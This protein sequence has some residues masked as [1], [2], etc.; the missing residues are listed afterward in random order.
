MGL[1]QVSGECFGFREDSEQLIH[2]VTP[3]LSSTGGQHRG[4]IGFHID[5]EVLGLID[6]ALIPDGT[7]LAGVRNES[8]SGTRIPDPASRRPH[9]SQCFHLD[10]PSSLGLSGTSEPLTSVLR[11]SGGEFLLACTPS[12]CKAVDMEHAEALREFNRTTERLFSLSEVVSFAQA[13]LSYGLSG[14]F[15]TLET[16]LTVNRTCKG[17]FS[18]SKKSTGF[19]IARF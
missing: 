18:R 13:T 9:H 11:R 3:K 4:A 14:D 6:D 5:A 16:H 17:I 7:G 8:R 15:C 19:D 2:D 1:V 12:S 10:V